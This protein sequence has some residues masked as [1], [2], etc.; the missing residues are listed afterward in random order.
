MRRGEIRWVRFDPAE[1]SSA[2][3]RRPA[4]IVSNNGANRAAERHGRG[5]V[6]VVPV[7]S[8]TATVFPFQ[9]LVPLDASGLKQDSKAQCQQVRS[10]SVMRIG[11]VIGTL[12]TDLMDAIDGA[13]KVHLGL[14]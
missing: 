7:S 4:I 11:G 10:V 13:L 12:S 14:E 1:G 2:N 3:K 9:V 5:V 6:T 8:N